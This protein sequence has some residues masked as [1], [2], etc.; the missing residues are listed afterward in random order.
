MVHTTKN[1]RGPKNGNAAQP[2][3]CIA[4]N[5]KF[6]FGSRLFVWSE[7]NG[8][9]SHTELTKLA[10]SLGTLTH[11]PLPPPPLSWQEGVF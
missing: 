6:I 8:H 9:I 4:G 2:P 10:K 11:F 5:I 3:L 7:H 1:G